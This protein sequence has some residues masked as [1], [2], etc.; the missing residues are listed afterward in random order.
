M[1]TKHFL[2][3]VMTRFVGGRGGFARGGEDEFVIVLHVKIPW[4]RLRSRVE[5]RDRKEGDKRCR[6]RKSAVKTI[7]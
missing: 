6:A 3:K 1:S 5:E 4:H 2:F 7:G